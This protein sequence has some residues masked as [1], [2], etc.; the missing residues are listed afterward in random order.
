MDVEGNDRGLQKNGNCLETLREPT[1][2]VK[3]DI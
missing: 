2:N 3:E 1:E